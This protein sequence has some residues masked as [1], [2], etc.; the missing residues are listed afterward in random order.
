M[1]ASCL[2]HF[3]HA[4]RMPSLTVEEMPIKFLLS[5]QVSPSHLPSVFERFLSPLVLV[6]KNLLVSVGD[7]RD[8]SL[9]PGLGRS[10]GGGHGNPYQLFCLENLTDSGACQDSKESDM[11]E[12]T[13]MHACTA[14]S[15]EVLTCSSD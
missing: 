9:I 3:L 13:Y 2:V 11:T 5:F 1:T 4:P 12:A 10:P 15:Q 8:T 6:V 7:I 14:V